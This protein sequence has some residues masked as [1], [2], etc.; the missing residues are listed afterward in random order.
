MTGT[1][2]YD[3]RKVI[4]AKW[5]LWGRVQ[6]VV[7]RLPSGDIEHVALRWPQALTKSWATETWINNESPP[8]VYA[9]EQEWQ[10]P[11]IVAT[12]KQRIGWRSRMDPA[13]RN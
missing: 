6:H 10:P 3:D 4:S 7:F 8:T 2:R 11:L 1:I 9:A 13:G 5:G 12:A